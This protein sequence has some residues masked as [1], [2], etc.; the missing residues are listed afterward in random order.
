[1]M[2]TAHKR[3]RWDAPA[4]QEK[5][6]AQMTMNALQEHTVLQ[7]SDGGQSTNGFHMMSAVRKELFMTL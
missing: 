5:E 1:M 7:Q 3:K 2:I 4:M 6:T